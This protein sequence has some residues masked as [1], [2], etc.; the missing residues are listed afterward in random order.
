MKCKT[1]LAR[2]I[3]FIHTGII[4]S[5]FQFVLVREKIYKIDAKQRFEQNYR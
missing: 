1:T 4:E 2:F 5:I 3:L